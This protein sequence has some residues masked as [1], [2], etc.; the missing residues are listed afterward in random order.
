MIWWGG[1]VKSI[2]IINLCIR[3]GIFMFLVSACFLEKPSCS[4]KCIDVISLGSSVDLSVWPIYACFILQPS[5]TRS[6]KTIRN[7][8]NNTLKD[9]T[10]AK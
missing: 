2:E 3:S 8:L 6:L 5:Q 1:F 10:V 4:Q 7:L 9:V